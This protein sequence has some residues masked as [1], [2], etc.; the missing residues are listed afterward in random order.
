MSAASSAASAVQQQFQ[1]NAPQPVVGNLNERDVQVLR[2]ACIAKHK[3]KG[4][5]INSLIELVTLVVGVWAGLA[6]GG[7]VG[8]LVAMA[9]MSATN[10]V[11]KAIHN[12]LRDL[13]YANIARALRTRDFQQFIVEREYRP[14]LEAMPEIYA[15]YSHV[16]MMPRI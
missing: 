11:L 9:T 14:S 5:T 2:E 7:F 8:F 6:I 1:A 3:E 10:G 12:N 13:K 15:T 16:L 4:A